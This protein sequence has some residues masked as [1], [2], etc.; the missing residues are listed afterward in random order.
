MGIVFRQSVKTTIIIFA[1]A[2]LGAL[3]LF[4]ST[5]LIPKQ[6]LGF[7]RTLTTQALMASQLF[8]F[9]LHN[10]LSVYIHQYNNSDK[11]KH[12]LIGLCL[13]LP[14][15]LVGISTIVYYTFRYQIVHL[16]KP[17]DITFIQRYF[18]WLPL[19][20][21]LFIYLTILEQFLASQMKVALSTF[22]KEIVVRLANIVLIVLFGLQL[23]TF[24]AFIAGTVLAYLIPV[25]L[26]VIFSRRQ[27]AFGLSLQINAFSKTE[28]KELL[29]FT[30]YHWLLSVSLTLM[31]V[32]D[33]LML[34]P[35]SP[36]GLSDVSVYTNAIFFI[37]FLQIPYRAM[38]SATF[39]EFAKTFKTN[40][41]NKTQDLFHRS[42]I[43]ILIA[44]LA[45]TILICVNMHN[46]VTVMK[47]GYEA[48]TT[49]VYILT[50]GTLIDIATGMNGQVLSV[51]N[52]YKANF[53]FSLT[54]VGLM[55]L[56]YSLFIPRYG[57]YGAAWGSAAALIIY[58]VIKF[59]YVWKKLGLQPFTGKTSLLLVAGAVTFCAGYFYPNLTNPYLDTFIR[60]F[61]VISI[62]ILML[63]WLKPSADLQQYISSV[64]KNKRLF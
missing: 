44:S 27:K 62:Y 61:I 4:L 31:G 52:Y 22:T 48:M 56:F 41:Q 23:I 58:N 43:N 51:S 53:Y 33:T 32:L 38:V 63:L 12:V 29:H 13:L 10:T 14:I 64:R 47:K 45:I 59:I 20:T 42:S 11:R 49:L 54:L 34:G 1:G 57:I 6:Q 36:N 37:S 24:D 9:G 21:L 8:M 3:V 55:I 46:A 15:F 30:W 17:E 16:F 18:M 5:Q 28:L 50:I 60:S 2:I 7:S 25:S 39:P 40:D 19:F 35:L 26:L